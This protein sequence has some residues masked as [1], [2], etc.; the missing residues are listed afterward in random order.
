MSIVNGR[1]YNSGVH[2]VYERQSQFVIIYGVVVLEEEEENRE[3]T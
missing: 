1:V 2:G 3:P